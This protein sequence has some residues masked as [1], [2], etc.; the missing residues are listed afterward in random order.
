[1][2]I[3]MLENQFS[4]EHIIPNSSNWD[5]EIDKDRIG[6]LT[7]IIVRMN[8]SRGNRHINFYESEKFCEFMKDIIPNNIVYDNIVNHEQRKPK[9]IN[10]DAYNELCE[11]NQ[12]IYKDNFIKCLF[13]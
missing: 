7:P 13:K 3:N 11:K 1:M 6:N 5:D 12:K 4:L 10:N 2:P 8:S 9:V